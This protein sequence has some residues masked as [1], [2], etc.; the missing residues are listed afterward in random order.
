MVRRP[1]RTMRMVLL[2]L[3]VVAAVLQTRLWLSED[4]WAE[5]L[6]LRGS[7][8]GQTHENLTLNERN[9][10][11]RAEVKDLK[12][13]FVALEERARADLGMVGGEESFYLLMPASSEVETDD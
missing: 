10:R 1:S 4:G 7:V 8:A 11:L 12:E 2:C 3:I 6:H 9:A 5:V 13:G